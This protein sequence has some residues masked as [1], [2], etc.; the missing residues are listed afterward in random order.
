MK[1]VH[2]GVTSECPNRT[3]RSAPA[4]YM[5]AWT[6][7]IRL[8]E[9]VGDLHAVA[10]GVSDPSRFASL[11]RREPTEAAG[12]VTLLPASPEPMP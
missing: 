10:V 6:S 12:L 4:T 3:A 8:L 9:V 7:S 1:S 2:I 5:T 11:A